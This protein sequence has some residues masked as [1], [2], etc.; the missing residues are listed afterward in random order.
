[1]K[2]FLALIFSV[3]SI[4]FISAHDKTLKEQ[5]LDEFKKEHYSEAIAL[6][7]KAAVE[8]PDDAEVYYYLGWFNHYRAYD[9]RPL[10]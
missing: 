7:E 3:F 2:L 1:M 6:L 4:S 5:A 8:S 9:S 10:Q